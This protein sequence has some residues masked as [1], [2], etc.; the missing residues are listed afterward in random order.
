[1]EL[2]LSETAAVDTISSS[3]NSLRNCSQCCLIPWGR[4]K[5]RSRGNK[6]M[7]MRNLLILSSRDTELSHDISLVGTDDESSAFIMALL[8]NLHVCGSK[9]SLLSCHRGEVQSGE[10]ADTFNDKD[11]Y[12]SE[13]GN[14][15][16]SGKRK[17][18]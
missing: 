7:K 9:V 4:V 6:E 13:S 3:P 5:E 10:H 15:E 12:V 8:C 16:E 11:N 1:M 18:E 14:R 17:I 2:S